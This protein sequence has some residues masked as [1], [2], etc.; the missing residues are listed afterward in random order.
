MERYI[1]SGAIQ[2]WTQ[3]FGDPKNPPVLLIMGATNQGVLWPESFYQKLVQNGYF[4]ILFDYR[5]TGKSSAVDFE[6]FPYTIDDLADDVI[7]I[8]DGYGIEKTHL[9]GMS[10]GGQVAQNIAIRF[11]ERV[12]SLICLM[13]SPDPSVY[14]AAIKGEDVSVFSL[15]PP[16][17]EYLKFFHEISAR[18][19]QTKSERIQRD[20]D[21]WK[22]LNGKGLPFDEKEVR[23]AVEFSYER[24]PYQHSASNHG[25]CVSISPSRTDQLQQI[26][27][28]TLVI[29]GRQ[30]PCLPVEHATI[31]AKEI[32]GAKLLIIP[33]MGHAFFSRAVKLVVPAVLKHL[34]SEE[35]RSRESGVRRI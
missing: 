19:P 3:S 9:I 6:K 1:N 33:E 13:S 10:M 26:K 31:M 14:V 2:I 23:K 11:P 25:R 16:P 5:D 30:D 21:F 17:E 8:L 27:A 20:I 32:P 4:V 18:S 34:G 24:N 15:P 28:P 7:A 29:H 12:I 22:F 35:F